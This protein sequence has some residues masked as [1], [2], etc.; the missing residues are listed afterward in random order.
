MRG[1]R[2]GCAVLALPLLVGAAVPTVGWG[3]DSAELGDPLTL[4]AVTDYARRQNPEIRAAA[5]KWQA[6]LARPAQASALPDPM[7]DVAYHNESFDRFTQG[8]KHRMPS[9]ALVA[10]S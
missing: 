3:I 7:V 10:V 8:N 1:L 4:D 5:A 2:S 9:M 6:A